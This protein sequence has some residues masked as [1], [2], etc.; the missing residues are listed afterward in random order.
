M[1]VNI[2][3]ITLSCINKMFSISMDC[4]SGD[5]LSYNNPFASYAE[6]FEFQPRQNLVVISSCEFHESLEITIINER[7]TPLTVGETRLRIQAVKCL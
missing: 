4:Q 2:L 3:P 5:A 1:K 6:M 7:M